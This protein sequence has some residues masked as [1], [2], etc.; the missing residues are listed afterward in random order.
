ML[1]S[2]SRKV[3]V[4]SSIGVHVGRATMGISKAGLGLV[5][6]ASRATLHVGEDNGPNESTE[7]E[8]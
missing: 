5:G 8:N 6:A 3:R 4:L 7:A 2:S 1:E